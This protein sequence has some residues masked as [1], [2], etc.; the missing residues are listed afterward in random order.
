MWLYTHGPLDLPPIHYS[1]Y[2]PCG[3][4]GCVC[5]YHGGCLSHNRATAGEPAYYI[6]Y[7]I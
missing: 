6:I 1:I 3:D 4:D 2:L 7:L 5:V